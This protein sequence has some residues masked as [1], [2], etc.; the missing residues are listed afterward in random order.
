MK[1]SEQKAAS[2]AR[3][4]DLAAQRLRIEGLAGN[5]VQRLMRDCGLTHGGF[6][7]HFA[8]KQ[9]LD[10]AALEVAMAEQSALD[11]AL[12]E[13]LPLAE[14]R[15]ARARRYL[16]RHHRDHPETGCPLAALLSEAPRA[17]APLREAYQ[18]LLADSVT[19]SNASPAR[20][21]QE[22]A[23]TALAMGGLALARAVP[24]PALSDAILRACREAA[25]T[26]ADAYDETGEP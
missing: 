18:A 24:D 21:P 13:N 15:K 17:G 5:G 14:R 23:L 8:N 7:V 16:S 20:V 9:A 26:L 12:P 11:A 22:L 10:V 2:R 1:R 4:L 3:I 25:D 19:Q 6:T